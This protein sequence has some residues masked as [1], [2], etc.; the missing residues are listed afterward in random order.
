M[1]FMSIF[2]YEPDK[3]DEVL[4]RRAEGLFTPDGA[5]CIGNW[6]S[7]AGGRA[8]TLFEVDNPL[9]AAQWSHVW[10]DLGKF[11]V[12]PVVDTDELMKAMAAA[13]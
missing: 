3:R 7:T 10:N 8:F 4:K 5:K 9:A 1:L 6:S 12:Y 11:E 13:R 2:T